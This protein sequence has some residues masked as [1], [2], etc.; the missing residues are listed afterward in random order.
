[1]CV[2]IWGK[3]VSG[4]GKRVKILRRKFFGVCGE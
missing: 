3:G 2:L 1:M 4:R